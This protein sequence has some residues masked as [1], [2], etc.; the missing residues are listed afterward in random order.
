MAEAAILLALRYPD[1]RCVLPLAP[2]IDP[3]FLGS[4]THASP[5][6]IKVIQG[7]VHEVLSSCDV[8]LVASGTATLDTAIMGVPM[9]IVYKVSLVS[10][11]VGKMVIK[12]P[13]IGLVNLVAGEEVVPELIQHEVTAGRLA[14]EVEIILEDRDVRA[15][16]KDNLKRV[17]ENLGRGGASE[18]TARIA[19]EMMRQ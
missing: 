12:V 2:T 17:K 6:E 4:F 15:K 13:H 16:M 5:V 10:Y 7:H 19:T 1:I 3:E 14:R 18:R 9:A 11:L 8:A